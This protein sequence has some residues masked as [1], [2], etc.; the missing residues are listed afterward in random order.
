M[1]GNEYQK[2]AL[3]TARFN[4]MS[5]EDTIFNCSLGLSGE[6]GEFAD[7]LKKNMFQGHGFNR[8]HQIKELGDIMWYVALGAHAMDCTLEEVMEINIAKLKARYPNGFDSEKS[9]N[10]EV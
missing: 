6:S 2:L 9:L 3:T 5:K 7:H 8:D 10:R 1:T 4:E